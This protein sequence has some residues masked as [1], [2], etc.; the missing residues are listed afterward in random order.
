MTLMKRNAADVFREFESVKSQANQLRQSLGDALFGPTDELE[1]VVEG[2][3]DAK[4]HFG[5][6]AYERNMGVYLRDI[7]IKGED[8]SGVHKQKAL[9]G[10]IEVECDK[11]IDALESGGTPFSEDDLDK[12]TALKEQLGVLLEVLPDANYEMNLKE[13]MD[14][15][16]RG[17][18]LASALISSRV[19][20]Y[21]LS[22]IPGEFAEEKVQFLRE[23]WIAEGDSKDVHESLIRAN[24]RARN[25]FSHDISVFPSASDAFSLLSDAI[26]IFEIMSSEGNVGKSIEK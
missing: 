19:I 9:L 16:Q 21:A 8:Y 3:K 15:Y 13:A 7:G 20:L 1:N 17:A 4:M 24:R 6:V 25:F 5:G 14:E 11:A 23:K 18:Y 22:Q 12:L 10:E 26:A 2:Y